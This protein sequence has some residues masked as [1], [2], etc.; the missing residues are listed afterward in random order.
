MFHTLRARLIAISIAIV[1]VALVLLSVVTF[2]TVRANVLTSLDQQ[3][4]GVTRQYARE[5]TEWVQDK[6]RIA[7]SLKL[8]TSLAEPQPALDTARQAGAM[9]SV[10]FSMSDKR[11]VYSGWTVP[12]D[13]DGTT[14][15]W[16]K[17]AVSTG[18]P[19]ITAAY[20]DANTGELYV[21]F[22]EPVFAQAGGAL[23]GVV[24]ADAKLT[25][26]VKKVN[27]IHPTEKSFAVLVDGSN[28][29]ILAHARK[30]LTL[31][32]VTDLAKGLDAALLGRLVKDGDHA[33]L[34]IDGATQMVYAARVEG[35]SWILLIAVDRDLATASLSSMLKMTIVI[36]VLCLLAA[37]ALMSVFVSRQLRR[38]IL[39]RDALEDIASGE[40]DLTRR[41]DASGR[42][43]L[44]QIA[45]AFNRF[46]DKIA[47]VLLQI[48]EASDMVRTASGEIA[49]GNSDLSMR[50]ESQA[51]ALEETSAA[52][53]ELMA[54]VQQNAENAAQANELAASATQVAGRGGEVVQQVVQTM[55]DI[56]VASRKIVDIIGTID[57]IAFQTNILAL[58]A[59]VE[60]ARA[61]EMG[62]GFAVVATE[63][64]S[65]AGRSAEAAREIKALIGD[66][67]TQV[68][69]GSRLVASAGSTMTE[70]VDSIRQLAGIVKQISNASH[71]QS[72]GITEVGTAVT[73]MDENTQQNAALVEQAAAA[74]QS[75]QQ[76]A[77]ALAEV[78]AGFKLPQGD[79][80]AARDTLRLR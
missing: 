69:A 33:E 63:V 28:N 15:P 39:V 52:M 21:S 46:A 42:D 74:A 25:S 64:R 53:E 56:N 6:Q 51:S 8:S 47:A 27:A 50:T 19:A 65:L 44:T 71:E 36:T 11:A 12:P 14:R 23:A 73:Q 1:A 34:V 72:S 45:S 22:V 31:K 35:T 70:V 55:G 13:F 43:E 37:G 29:T 9:D 58:N 3:I 57:G 4:S 18:G 75:L 60:A 2:V 10:G 17:L 26:V 20:A 41:M 30:E 61:G 7:S 24:S 79:A 67:V 68:D 5:L 62:R 66:S 80:P 40:G 16:Y 78:V 49:S 77:S 48:R 38:M 76:Q 54:T 32:P 59:A